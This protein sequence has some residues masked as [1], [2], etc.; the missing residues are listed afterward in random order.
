MTFSGIAFQLYSV[1]SHPDSLS[2]IIRRVA[3]TGYDGVEFAHRFQQESSEDIAV[4]LNETGIKPVAVHADLTTIENALAGEA[5]LLE[6]CATIG[7]KRLIVAHPN[8]TH[9]HT[10]ESVRALVDRLN[11]VAKALDQRG[12]ELGL[13]N[14]RRW[15]SP[16][17]PNTVETLIDV[18]PAPDRVADYIQE[19]G[20]RLQSRH[21]GDVSR[22]TPFWHLIME[23]DPD[24]IWFELEAAELHAGGVMPT[25]AL[26]LLD[27]RTKMLHLRDVAPGTGFS[28]YESVP[29]GEG[30]VDMKYILEAADDAGIDWVVYENELDL[31]PEDKIKA[32][33]R[34]SDRM[35]GERTTSIGPV[36]QTGSS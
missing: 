5:D 26:S 21:A 12:L 8:S 32:G 34:F 3:A 10:R 11:D 25:E 23:T 22:K 36:H 24:T 7:C 9:F 35:L 19:A 2:E 33:R 14:D 15:L 6:R 4:V 20:R 29:H 17:L 27:G 28:D 31:P 16:L 18:T 1:R 13:H 30:V